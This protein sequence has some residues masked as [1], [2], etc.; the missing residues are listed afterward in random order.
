MVRD[1]RVRFDENDFHRILE[2]I[3]LA[4][5]H[6]DGRK[7]TVTSIT[8]H[9]KE[10]GQERLLEQ[11]QESAKEGVTRLLTAFYFRQSGKN[12]VGDPTFEFTHKSFGEYLAA[13][14]IVRQIKLT[15]NQFV[16]NREDSD[17]GWRDKIALKKWAKM[18]GPSKISSEIFEFLMQE[19]SLHE[20]D[21]VRLWVKELVQ[22][23]SVMLRQGMPIP[24]IS[25]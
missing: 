9:C 15:V 8:R 22:L 4:V 2:E 12:K 10:V 25:P 1:M 21:N 5:W 7:A 13:C 6:D 23:V 3:A 19:V 20:K 17:T 18:F 11:Y 16:L 14:R 24:H